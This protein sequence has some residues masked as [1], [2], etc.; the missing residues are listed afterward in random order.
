M[1]EVGGGC[2][3]GYPVGDVEEGWSSQAQA[4][5]AILAESREWRDADLEARL[6]A[7]EAAGFSAS[8]KVV[9]LTAALPSG[10]L[11]P[12]TTSVAAT[13]WGFNVKKLAL[14]SAIVAVLVAGCGSGGGQAASQPNEAESTAAAESPN[15]GDPVEATCEVVESG[16]TAGAAKTDA[17]GDLTVGAKIAN[18]SP[19]RTAVDVEVA[20]TIL[21]AAGNT[22]D[23]TTLRAS[24]IPPNSFTFIGDKNIGMYTDEI[25][26][27]ADVEFAVRCG[28]ADSTEYILQTGSTEDI[29][30]KGS[31]ITFGGS[32]TN[33][34]AFDIA[35]DNT[36]I[37]L[38]I[39]D[40]D[41]AI[42][43]GGAAQLDAFVSPGKVATWSKTNSVVSPKAAK[44][45]DYVLV[46]RPPKA[47]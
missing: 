46:I 9:N 23:T 24:D 26:A 22:L 38:V 14:V 18:T 33:D 6:Q 7:S 29:E 2:V 39:R 13:Q 40:K 19:N 47:D 43:G 10:P 31:Y 25:D 15:S 45:V 21:D 27:A 30:R 34:Q 1:S 5:R 16:F 41:G 20:L 11:T 3:G 36:E 8:L 28:S 12:T 17:E 4:A 35:A 37:E 42:I 44:S 32:L